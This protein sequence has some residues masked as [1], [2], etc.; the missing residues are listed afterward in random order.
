MEQMTVRINEEECVI[1]PAPK[2]AFI[3]RKEDA[4]PCFVPY[5]AVDASVKDCKGGYK[6][7]KTYALVQHGLDLEVCGKDCPL[8]TEV[9]E[10]DLQGLYEY[11][12]ENG[13]Q[14]M[15]RVTMTLYELF[16][17]H[18]TPITIDANL[19]FSNKFNEHNITKADFDVFA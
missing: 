14:N 12:E 5:I 18:Q 13:C 15:R 6:G 19:W 8:L 2:G 10:D 11:F 7:M 3:I 1:M 17:D 16:T 9:I 4:F